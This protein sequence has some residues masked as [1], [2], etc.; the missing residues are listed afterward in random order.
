MRCREKPF[1]SEGV[2]EMMPVADG[3]CAI[4]TVGLGL[5]VVKFGFSFSVDDEDG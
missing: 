1:T 2:E 5:K 4:K 3:R